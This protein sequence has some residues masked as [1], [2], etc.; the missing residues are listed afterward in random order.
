MSGCCWELVT[1]YEPTILSEPLFN[2]IVMEDDEGDG[3]LP[4]P[5]CAD[6]SDGCQVFCE[7]NDLPDQFVASKTGPRRRGRGFSI[8]TRCGC[9]IPD[10][11][12]GQD[13]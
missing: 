6:E 2:A 3:C 12:S 1:A 13:Y 8:S 11:L 9:Q 4:D 7:T 10:P 5:S